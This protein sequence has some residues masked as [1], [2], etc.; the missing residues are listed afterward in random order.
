MDNSKIEVVQRHSI[1]E[2]RY[3]NVTVRFKGREYTFLRWFVEDEDE[4]LYDKGC[5]PFDSE[6]RELLWAL[7]E[8]EQEELN[9]AIES[10]AW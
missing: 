3:E 5:E 9:D 7:T 10:L 2:K 4:H 6:N 8:D 1:S